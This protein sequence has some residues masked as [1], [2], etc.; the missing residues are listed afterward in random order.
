MRCTM[1]EMTQVS[2]RLCTLPCTITAGFFAHCKLQSQGR[3][4]TIMA[5]QLC[6]IRISMSAVQSSP[7][8]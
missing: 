7:A 2:V 8:P 3:D 4:M 5:S 6:H 1:F